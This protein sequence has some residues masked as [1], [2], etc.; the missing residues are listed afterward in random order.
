MWKLGVEVDSSLAIQKSH[1]ACEILSEIKVD[2]WLIWIRETMQFRDPALSLVLDMDIISPTAL[3]YTS[4]GQRIA[5]AQ[6]IDAR[7]LPSGPFDRIVPYEKG[8]RDALRSELV[9]LDPAQIAINYSTETVSADGLTLGMY[10]NL[11]EHLEGTPYKDRLMSA[12]PLMER[13]KGRKLP[14]EVRRIENA[15]QVTE[16]IFNDL[17]TY[18]QPG[19]AETEIAS[20]VRERMMAYE[21]TASWD[22][23]YCPAVDTGPNKIFGHAGPTNSR[24][25]AGHLLHFDFGVEANG[26]CSDLQRMFFFGRRS[27]IPAEVQHALD[28]VTGAIEAAAAF[29]RPGRIGHEVDAVAR[30]HIIDHGYEEYAHGL[31]HQVGRFAHDGGMRL[32]PQWELFGQRCY[33]IVEEGNVFTIEPNALTSNYGRV[34]LEEDVLVEA[35]GCRFLST[36]QRALICLG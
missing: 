14:E 21:V 35:N 10:R 31:G 6:A 3:L 32:A 16:R 23:A 25:R 26:Y 12:A 34:S 5:V 19:Q 24:T 11:L 36:P 33:G 28:T 7:G 20:Y 13:L 27:E 17:A 1:Q 30:R 22:P 8:I 4:D 29:L 18:L 9:R 2:C 15:V